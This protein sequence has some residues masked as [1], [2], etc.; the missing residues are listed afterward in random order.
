MKKLLFTLLILFSICSCNKDKKEYVTHDSP[1]FYDNDTLIVGAWDYLFT[2]HE[3]GYTGA[4]AKIF[5]NRPS[6]D[7]TSNGYYKMTRYNTTMSSG[8]IDTLGYVEKNR[9]VVFYPNGVKSQDMIFQTLH[10]QNR[11]TLIMGLGGSGDFFINAW[12]KR[13]NK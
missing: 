5:E 12:Y 13:V 7:I 8:V 2:W 3:G 11:D 4:S 6:M 1:I 10:T 9:L